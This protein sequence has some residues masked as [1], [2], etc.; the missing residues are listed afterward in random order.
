MEPTT[1]SSLHHAIALLERRTCMDWLDHYRLGKDLELALAEHVFRV[2]VSYTRFQGSNVSVTV[3]LKSVSG[4]LDYDE[5]F[6]LQRAGNRS[7]VH[8]EPTLD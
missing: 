2:D 4:S 8:R 6:S 7:Y 5:F 3:S 1:Y